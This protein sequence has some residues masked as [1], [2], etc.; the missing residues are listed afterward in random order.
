MAKID[1]EFYNDGTTDHR[2]LFENQITAKCNQYLANIQPCLDNGVDIDKMEFYTYA[3][4]E[5]YNKNN[6]NLSSFQSFDSIAQTRYIDL[7]KIF[8]I[9]TTIKFLY[10][11]NQPY[12]IAYGG[13]GGALCVSNSLFNLTNADYVRIPEKKGRLPKDAPVGSNKTLD[14]QYAASDGKLIFYVECKGKEGTQG[15]YTDKVNSILAKKNALSITGNRDIAFGIINIMPVEPDLANAEC[16]LVDP[17]IPDFEDDPLLFKLTARLKYY[18]HR[19]GFLG[20]THWLKQIR[21]ILYSSSPIFPYNILRRFKT[22]NLDR[23]FKRVTLTELC[24]VDYKRKFTS[25]YHFKLSKLYTEKGEQ[26]F[27]RV[28]QLPN[29]KDEYF[30][31]GFIDD[32]FVT[33]QSKPVNDFLKFKQETQ[34]SQWENN[35]MIWD[36]YLFKKETRLKGMVTISNTGELSGIL[37]IADQ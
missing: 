21:E 29:R 7:D 20:N 32:F 33:M 36:G 15:T 25:G 8:N 26:A 24:T 31:Y 11:G 34:T 3:L 30:V 19:L 28:T 17:E 27:V 9:D 5:D 18:T 35:L 14:F 1:F 23:L 12:Y 22:E 16:V 10:P 6:P 4:F 13:C 2:T 37:S